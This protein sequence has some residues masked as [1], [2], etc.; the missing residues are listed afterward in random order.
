MA[1]NPERLIP[2]GVFCSSIEVRLRLFFVKY[3]E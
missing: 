1:K 3:Y 2:F